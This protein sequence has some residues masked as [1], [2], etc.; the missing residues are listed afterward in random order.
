[1]GETMWNAII[2]SA[3]LRFRP[4]MLTAIAA[5]LGM[6]PLIPNAFWGPMAVAM[7]G[8][9]LVA[10]ILT[11]LVLPAIYAAWYKVKRD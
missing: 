3:V 10:T 1:M 9:I 5:I 11:L 6:I 8:G 4:I 7:S 2:D